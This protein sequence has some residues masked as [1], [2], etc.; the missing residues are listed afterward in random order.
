MRVLMI[1]PSFPPQARP[2]GVGDYTAALVGGLATRGASLS[3]VAGA[4]A[5]PRADE[6]RPEVVRQGS[7]WGP[8]G[9][10]ATGRLLRGRPVEVV[11]IQYTPELYGA[12]LSVGALPWL[13]RRQAPGTKVVTTFHTLTGGPRRSAITAALLVAGSHGIIAV[14]EGIVRMIRRRLARQLGKVREIP[15]GSNI[16][17]QPGDA[18]AARRALAEGHGF[19]PDAILLGHFG[20]PAPGKGLE[21]LLE[22]MVLASAQGRFHLIVLGDARPEDREHLARLRDLAERLGI[23]KAVTWAGR[24]DPMPLSHALQALDLYVVPYDEGA[25]IRRGTL[26]AGIVHGLPIVTTEPAVPSRF[27]RPDE[28]LACVPARNAAALAECIASLARSPERRA[29]LAAAAAETARAFAWPAIA[30]ATIA[31]YREVTGG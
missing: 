14:H 2:C 26:I 23:A 5:L 7:G 15:I 1:C 10:A 13:L 28:N 11:H 21:T 29:R 4:G 19:D 8:R 18:A 16:P 20:F 9:V 6:G 24:L 30:D 27:L 17:V 22:A 12:S 31:L 25:S 3:V